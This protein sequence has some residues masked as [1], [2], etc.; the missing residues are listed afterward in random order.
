MKICKAYSKQTE[1]E[2]RNSMRPRNLAIYQ[3]HW[4]SKVVEMDS[5]PG[6]VVTFV[7]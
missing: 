7:V 6:P 2:A 3:L 4:R 5:M 1:R